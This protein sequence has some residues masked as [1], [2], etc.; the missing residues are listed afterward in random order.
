MGSLFGGMLA[1]AGNEVWLVDVWAE[2]VEAINQRGLRL[3]GIGGSRAVKHLKATVAAGDVG[4]SD[5]VLVFVKSPVTE[6]AVS[7]AG[8]L[9]GRSTLALTLQ[10]GL[11]NVERIASVIPRQQIIAGITAQGATVLGPGRVRHAGEGVTTIGEL[12]GTSSPR[13]QSVADTFNEASIQ[14]QTSDNVL[15]LIWG[16]LLV[17]VGINALTALTGLKNGQL[18]D[19]SETGDLLEMAVQEALRVVEAHGIRLPFDDPVAHT[20][21]IA[22]ATAENRSSMLQDVSHQ[23]P[24]EID[25]INGAIVREGAALG[26]ETPVN[27]T[28]THLVRLM[29]KTYA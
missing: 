28:L 7:Q 27:R 10:N 29:E 2:H 26:V 1:K 21:A 5:L 16:K 15:G 18:L 22:R 20:K 11:G 24:T 14:T 17:N 9:F 8:S 19:F 3:S 4:P 25:M 23:R 13:V 6:T 12:E